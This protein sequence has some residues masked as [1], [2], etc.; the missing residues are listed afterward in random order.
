L[1]TLPKPYTFKQSHGLANTRL[2]LGYAAVIIAAATF[3]ADWKLGWDETK[4]YTTIACV[5]YFILNTLLTYHIWRV[6]AG[7]IFVGVWEGGQ[8][9]RFAVLLHATGRGYV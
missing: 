4:G 3:Y 9:V 5:V 2:S 8:K 1:S 6:E 7:R